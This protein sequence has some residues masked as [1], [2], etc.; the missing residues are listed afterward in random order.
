M[1]SFIKNISNLLRLRQYYKNFLIFVGLFFS[2]N[3]FQTEHYLTLIIGFILLCFTSS[4]NYI[5]NDIVDVENDKEH[6]E[7]LHKK[8][9]ASGELSIKFAIFLLLILII[10]IVLSIVYLIPNLSFILLL[11]AII[12]TG[13]LYSHLLKNYA[14]VDILILSTGYLWRSLA[15]CFIIDQSISSWLLLAIFEVALFLVIAKRKGDLLAF[16][17]KEKAT[18]HKKVYNVYNLRLLDNFHN[19]TAASIFMTYSLYIF[20]KFK[21]EEFNDYIVIIS[22]PILIY[23]LMR[24]MYLTTEEPEIARNTEKAFLDKG[25]LI[26]GLLMG[27]VLLYSFYNGIIIDFFI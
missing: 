8:P 4:I 16:E 13:Q 10:S 20:D 25:I 7:K 18:K 6:Q 11:I 24:Y 19:L 26:A 21:L 27:L 15:G 3:L 22:I 5:I 9:L 1:A 12:I 2:E 14:F 23:I 17:N